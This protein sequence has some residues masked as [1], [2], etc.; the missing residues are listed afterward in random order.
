MG[1]IS[2]V[3]SGGQSCAVLADQK[4][5]G[6]ISAIHELASRERQFYCWLS[7]VRKLVFTPISNKGTWQPYIDV[8][9]NKCINMN[10]LPVVCLLQ[11][12]VLR[13]EYV[14]FFRWRLHPSLFFSL[15]E[16]F[17]AKRS[18]WSTL[19]IAYL[20]PAK[21]TGLWRHLATPADTHGALSG[22]LQRVRPDTHKSFIRTETLFF[23]ITY[24]F[25]NTVW[26]NIYLCHLPQ[27]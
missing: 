12:A 8:S 16:F 14:S 18:N 13:R 26:L 25:L 20:L 3:C 17:S 23:L 10:A 9:N 7:R 21:C 22:H 1:Y 2:S 4:V 6:F 24:F 27:R 5:M 15:W 19:H 11:R